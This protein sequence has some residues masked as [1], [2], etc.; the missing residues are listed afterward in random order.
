MTSIPLPQAPSPSRRD[1]LARALAT[2]IRGQVRFDQHDRMLY[3]TD[4]SLYQVEPIGVVV[5]ADTDDAR[6]VVDFCARH[7]VPLL[8]RGGGT[9]LAGQCTNHAVVMDLSVNCRSILE[10]DASARRV[11]VEPGITVDDLNDSITGSGLF[12]APDPATSR[13]ANIGGCIGNN[14]AGARS[15]RYGRTSESVISLDVAL[16]DGRPATFGAGTDRLGA[17][18]REITLAV[19]DI[20]ARYAPLIDARFPKTVRRNAGYGLDMVLAGMRRGG[21]NGEPVNPASRPAWLDHVNLAHLLCGSEGTLAVTLGATLALHPRPKF[22]GLAV[23]GFADLDEAIAAVMPILTTTPTAVE[24]LDDTV[25]DLARANTEYRTYVDLMPQPSSGELKAVLYVEYFAESAGEIQT[26]FTRLSSLLPGVAVQKHTDANAMLRAWKLRKAGEPLLHGIPGHRKPI[27]FIEDNAIPVENLTTFVKELRAIVASFG[28]RAAYYAHASVGVLHVRPLIDIHDESDRK[29]MREIAV[30]AADLA[31]SLGGVMS[32]EHGDGR[33]RGPLLE[34]FY[35]PELM[36]AFREV[37]AVFDPQNRL[38]P[39]NIVSPGPIESMTSSLRIMPVGRPVAVPSDISTYYDYSSQHGFDGAVEMCNGAGVCRKKQGGTMCPSYQATLDERHSTRGRGNAL[40]LAIT[41]QFGR[42][43]AFTDPGT[44]ETLDLCLSCKAC[45]T[46]CP[47]NVDIA[48]LKS[49]YLAQRARVSGGAPLGARLMGAIRT[50][51]KLGA[52]AHPIANAVS[53]LRPVRALI[54]AAL[55]IHPKRSLPHFSAPLGRAWTDSPAQVATV[56]LFGDCFSMYNESGIGLAAKRLLEA[57]GYRVVLADAGCC[58]RAKISLGL[59]DGAITE[60]D[61]TLS[62]LQPLVEDP[63]CVAILFSEPSCLSA[64]KD[65]WLTL[66]LTTP[67]ALREQLAAKS[68][69]TEDFIHRAWDQHP[70]K[71]TFQASDLRGRVMLHGHCHQKALWGT[72]SSAALIRRAVGDRLSVLDTGCCGMAG[73][74]GYAEHR[75]DL[76]NRIGELSLFPAARAMTE[77]DVLLA[78]GTSCR[79]QVRDATAARPLHPVEFLA[80]LLG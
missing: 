10:L 68:F 3:A 53:S 27:T 76:S 37:K 28:T 13:H 69:L 79:H 18:E 29:I 55:K 40:R 58:G 74:F 41:G 59:L 23:L 62:R 17:T 71:P 57:C 73:S 70:I 46:E 52:A 31:K 22:K 63:A 66:R 24:L 50:L 45:K 38:N 75:F 16:A 67:K 9:S 4:A 80:S 48:K 42:D 44:Y 20:V 54:N 21:W 30:R 64:I 12:F 19:C 72:E 34:R 11:R 25:V 61:E 5:P 15:I 78:P 1:E 33:V 65:D 2:H 49:E 56:A 36:E 32:G 26:A 39:G 47:S 14:A 7:S 43:N 60:A 77:H 51:N 6:A 35:G 8:P